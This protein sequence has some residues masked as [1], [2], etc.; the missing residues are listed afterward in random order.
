MKDVMTQ[1]NH[2]PA[3]WFA[4][5]NYVTDKENFRID[6]GGT[7]WGDTP[8]MLMEANDVYQ[9]LAI[10]KAL[11][12]YAKLAD[13]N[14]DLLGALDNLEAEASAVETNTSLNIAIMQARAVIA[15]ADAY[16]AEALRL[17]NERVGV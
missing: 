8:N 4:H 6:E 15:K 12:T 16:E 7:R 1:A 11:N 5:R 10:C 9:A 13:I 2:I 3:H 17:A 14:A